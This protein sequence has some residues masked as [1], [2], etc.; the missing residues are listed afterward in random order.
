MPAAV[1]GTRSDARALCKILA[2][3]ADHPNVA[4]VTVFSLGCQN[5]QISM[6]ERR[7]EGAEFKLRQALFDL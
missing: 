3:Y 5:A 6:F 4:G 7:V 1:A 2:A